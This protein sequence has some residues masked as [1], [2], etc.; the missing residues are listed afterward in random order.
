MHTRA[1][2]SELVEP[3]PEPE[4]TLNRRLHRR[5]RRVPFEQRNEPPAQPKVV[6]ASILDINHF[7]L[8][9]DILENYNP[10]WAADRV[11]AL[12]T[13][14]AIT[15]PETT[16]EFAIKRHIHECLEID[17]EDQES[18][19][20]PKPKD[21]KPVK[22]T[23][24][25]KPYK[26]KIPY[27][28]RLRKEKIKARIDVIDEILEEDFNVLLDKESVEVF[29]D[30]FFILGSSFDHCLN[31]LN[32][33]LQHYKD[34]NLV[35]NW[36]KCH[37]MVKEGI[38]LGQKVSGAGLEVDIAK[39]DRSLEEALNKTLIMKGEEDRRDE[40]GDGGVSELVV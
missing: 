27:P 14:F 32:K 22:E 23:L 8:F 9:F 35:L 21:P 11:V 5:N 39:I 36:E 24:I 15:I 6:Y 20:Q 37:F 7:C 31:N 16:N 10:M 3:V 4:C 2:N 17:D 25:P 26:P 1:S 19:P 18:T 28:Q 38:V 30:D 12:T 29:K 34:A 40:D 33:T 13:G